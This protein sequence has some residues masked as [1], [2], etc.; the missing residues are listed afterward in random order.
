MIK[1]DLEV[2]IKWKAKGKMAQSGQGEVRG[3]E[4]RASNDPV[5][6]KDKRAQSSLV[7]PPSPPPPSQQKKNVCLLPWLL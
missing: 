2:V 6:P 5:N 7:P 4:I 1:I 3:K